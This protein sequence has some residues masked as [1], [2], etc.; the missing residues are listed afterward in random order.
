MNE[1]QDLIAIC[2]E[3]GSE[4]KKAKSKMTALCPEC[5]HI[6]YGYEN[7]NHVFEDGKCIYC[8]WDGSRSEYIQSL[9]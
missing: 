3:C 5:A 9:I 4:F 8:F 6:L 1:N 2:E 7:C